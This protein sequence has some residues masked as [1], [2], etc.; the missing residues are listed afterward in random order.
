MWAAMICRWKGRAS[1]VNLSRASSSLV[2][3]AWCQPR[4]GEPCKEGV[5]RWSGETC[6]GDMKVLQYVNPFFGHLCEN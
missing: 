6:W 5:E 3:V 4:L 1:P 2:L